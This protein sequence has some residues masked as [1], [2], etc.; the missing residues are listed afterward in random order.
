MGGCVSTPAEEREAK[1]RSSQIDRELRNA[2]RDYG[3]TIKIL[4]LGKPFIYTPPSIPPFLS[5]FFF[6]PILPSFSLSLI[7][8]LLL[9]LFHTFGFVSDYPIYVIHRWLILRQNSS[10]SR[11][12]YSWFVH[13]AQ[14]LMGHVWSCSRF[15]GANLFLRPS[16]Q[17][18][19]TSCNCH[20]EVISAM[21][22]LLSYVYA[23]FC[24]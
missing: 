7:S 23:S 2:A 10:C 3:N 4:L 6:P 18:L 21:H 15:C 20:E 1:L 24:R 17:L 12:V 11:K 9:A 5:P 16:L 22:V 13:N 19:L 8:F 14:I